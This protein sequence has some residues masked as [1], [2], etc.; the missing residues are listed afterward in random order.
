MSWVYLRPSLGRLPSLIIMFWRQ[1]DP[2]S[3]TNTKLIGHN[4]HRKWRTGTILSNGRFFLPQTRNEGSQNLI[5][6]QL[7]WYSTVI[8]F[9]SD[10]FLD[11]LQTGA[12]PIAI[13]YSLEGTW[14]DFYDPAPIITTTLQWN[15]VTKPF[16]IMVY[17]ACMVSMGIIIIVLEIIM[18]H[19]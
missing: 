17:D 9:T 8:T 1:V 2:V 5:D 3:L 4:F 12:W 19:M 13:E 16:K 7:I 10:I 6:I 18:H 14:K 11:I 15:A